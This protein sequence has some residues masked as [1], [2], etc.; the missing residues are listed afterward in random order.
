MVICV[1]LSC[2]PFFWFS[3]GGVIL[4][5][6]FP[7]RPPWSLRQGGCGWFRAMPLYR[8]CEEH[9]WPQVESTLWPVS[10]FSWIAEC[11]YNTFHMVILDICFQRQ[12]GLIPSWFIWKPPTDL[13]VTGGPAWTITTTHHFYVFL[14]LALI[15]EH[16]GKCCSNRIWTVTD[17]NIPCIWSLTYLLMP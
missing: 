12:N 3:A 10:P 4:S 8:H 11:V 6:S 7:C 13:K 15:S 2:W 17:V 1:L 16:T 5:L 9:T 14:Y